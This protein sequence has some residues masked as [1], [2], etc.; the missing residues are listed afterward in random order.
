MAGITLG[1]W[2]RNYHQS[3]WKPNAE[4]IAWAFLEQKEWAATPQLLMYLMKFI[5]ELQDGQETK[6]QA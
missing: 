4:D 3:D 2:F 5:E 6:T 1:T